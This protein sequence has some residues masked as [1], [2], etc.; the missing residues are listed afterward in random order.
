MREGHGTGRGR[1]NR[2]REG[3]GEQGTRRGRGLFTVVLA[4]TLTAVSAVLRLIATFIIFLFF[5]NSSKS[6]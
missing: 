6:L 5:K 3:E 1:M 2:G 4:D